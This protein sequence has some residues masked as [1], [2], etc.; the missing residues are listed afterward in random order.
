MKK[1]LYAFLVLLSLAC[2]AVLLMLYTQHS[3]M[4]GQPTLPTKQMQIGTT[5][6]TVEIASTEQERTDGLSGRLSLLPAHGMLFIF[7][8]PGEYGFWMKEMRFSLD[9]IFINN[10]KVVTVDANL[11]PQT[12]P[13][14]FYPLS[15]AQYVLEVPAGFASEHSI[16][17]G[18]K[19]VLPS[20]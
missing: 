15:P 17:Q 6:L 2:V 8:S 19:V 13:E 18:S 11:S 16:M 12:Y 3:Y 14:A 9:I 1:I 20:L 10:A 7:D 5:T 4:L